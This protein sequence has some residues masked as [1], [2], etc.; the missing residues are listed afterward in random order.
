LFAKI[1]SEKIVE[2]SFMNK[3]N[4]KVALVT[5]CTGGLGTAICKKLGSS[6]YLAQ[7]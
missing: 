7:T 4:R 6:V 2:I 5:G 1:S 3:E